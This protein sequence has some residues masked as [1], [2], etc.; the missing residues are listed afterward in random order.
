MV[1][2]QLSQIK[3]WFKKYFIPHYEN[4]HKPH[5]LRTEVAVFV[6]AFVLLAEAVYLVPI[7][8][9]FNRSDY[10]AQ[11]LSSVLVDAAN[12]DRQR[13]NTGTLKVNPVLVQAAQMKAND[14]AAKG[15]FAHTSPSGVTP[16]YWFGQAGYKYVRA[17]ENLAVNFNDSSLLHQAWMNSP[18]HRANIVNGYYTEV[19][20]AMANGIYKGREATFV[21][22]L[23][24]QP[25]KAAAPKPVVAAK[26]PVP[27][28]V[29]TPARTPV[30]A[31][32]RTPTP[33]PT[34]VLTPTPVA[35][36]EAASTNLPVAVVS[37]EPTPTPIDDQEDVRQASFVEHIVS[38][39][40]TVADSLAMT[41]LIVAVLALCFAVFIKMEIQHPQLIIN[42]LILLI[43]LGGILIINQHLALANSLIF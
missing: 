7:G 41:G 16:W 43:V 15:Y 28:P 29:R 4:D 10:F 14:M 34:P 38:Q 13:L 1:K 9:V 37:N 33:T 20:I 21:V 19:G 6:L 11:I 26:T 27:T 5:F 36:V 32:A 22:Q 8:V 12:S 42:G 24:G 25:A 35:R 31:Q 39:P 30:V 17:G 23:F 2:E 40:Q 3:A 18:T